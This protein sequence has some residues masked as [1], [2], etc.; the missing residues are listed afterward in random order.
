[1][2]GLP[3]L[4]VEDENWRRKADEI[5]G[6]VAF[7]TETVPM[8]VHERRNSFVDDNTAELLREA[9][10]DLSS[11]RVLV[12]GSSMAELEFFVTRTRSLCCLDI[13]PNLSLLALQATRRRGRD[14]SWICGDGEALPFANESFDAV[15]VRQALHHMLNYGAAVSEFFRVCRTGGTVAVIDEPFAPVDAAQPPLA[16]VADR[17]PLYAEVRLGDARRALGLEPQPRDT[18]VA[19]ANAAFEARGGYIEPVPGDNESLLADKY[20]TLSLPGLLHAVSAITEGVRVFF[21]RNVGWA[22][23]SGA[24]VKFMHGPNPHR[25]RPLVERLVSGGNA[26]VVMQKT[27]RLERPRDRSSLRPVPFEK[28]LTLAQG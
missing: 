26:S 15:V 13:V 7:N 8:S 20:Q 19:P 10:L 12:V 11:A 21:P 2:D 4:L 9:Q 27:R 1:V 24:S 17:H 25:G 22:E 5:A 18:E 3:I 28:C 6:E 23:G 16:T 14:A